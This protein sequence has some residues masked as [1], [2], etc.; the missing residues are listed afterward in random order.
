MRSPSSKYLMSGCALGSSAFTPLRDH[1]PLSK[2]SRFY[3]RVC[4]KALEVCRCH[5]L[6]L[7]RCGGGGW[8]SW[9]MTEWKVAGR[10]A[11]RYF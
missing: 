5:K 11:S 2:E 8:D 3:N 10:M 7:K 1:V 6:E 9:M 4:V